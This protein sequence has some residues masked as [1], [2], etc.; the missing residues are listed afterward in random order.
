M[1]GDDWSGWRRR[2]LMTALGAAA[3]ASNGVAAA[4]TGA[5]AGPQLGTRER[6]LRMVA[7]GIEPFGQLDKAGLAS[8]LAVDL[9]DSVSRESGIVITSSVAPYQR[10]LAMMS[11]GLADIMI[12]ISNSRLEQVATPLATF[13]KGDVVVVGRAGTR[14]HSLAD[15]RGKMVGQIRGAEYVEAAIADA[16]IIKH[17]TSSL[18]QT[19]RMLLEGRYEAA[20]GFRGAMFYVLRTMNVPREKLGAT[21]LLSQPDVWLYLSR[22]VQEPAINAALIKAANALRERGAVKEL[23]AHYFGGLASE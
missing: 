15:L 20:I 2:R 9:A 5:S 14:F 23:L 19:M 11:S 1:P 16:G 18:E 10:A 17:E 13:F 4:Q 6:P 8:G 21:L 3:L 7:L 12:T 22:K